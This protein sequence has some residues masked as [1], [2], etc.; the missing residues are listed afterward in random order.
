MIAIPDSVKPED[1]EAYR[2]KVLNLTGVNLQNIIDATGE[3]ITRGG[4]T[5]EI[6]RLESPENATFRC[7]GTLYIPKAIKGKFKEEYNVW[8]PNGRFMALGEHKHD[9]VRKADES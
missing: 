8:K 1:A 3:Y 2:A 6:D 5:V 9:I 7:A 4:L